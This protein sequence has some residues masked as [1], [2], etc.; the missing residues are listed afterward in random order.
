M[1]SFGDQSNLIDKA[2][3]VASKGDSLKAVKLLQGALRNAESDLPLILEIMHLYHAI[4]KLNEVIIWAEKGTALS[5]K[6][7]K[8][9]VGEVE[10]LFYGRGKP[11]RL[12]EYLMEKWIEKMRE[13]GLTG[14]PPY[15]EWFCE[16]HYGVAKELKDFT[17]TE[18]IDLLKE[19]FS[20]I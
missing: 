8:K 7:K 14:H 3:R 1:F 18:A 4:D 19:K 10:D 16:K 12:A 13:E 20:E 5:A 17:I 9:V 2:R 6:A 15:V 11:D